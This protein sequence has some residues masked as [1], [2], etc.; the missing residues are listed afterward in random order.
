M[1]VV[2]YCGRDFYLSV[3]NTT[4]AGNPFNMTGYK[5]V[6]TVK[7]NINDPDSRALYQGGPWASS[8]LAFGKLTFKIPHA[9]TKNWWLAPPSG[10]GPISTVSVYDV[11]YADAASPKNWSTML[12]GAVNLQQVVTVTIPGG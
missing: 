12:I 3:T 7:A 6:M 1:D 8:E 11:S 2:V 9:T 10:S 4:A 5:T